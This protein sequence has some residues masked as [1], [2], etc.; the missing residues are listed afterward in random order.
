MTSIR[1]TKGQLANDLLG[2]S[3]PQSGDQL[4]DFHGP[5]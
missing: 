4:Q 2:A 3:T 5:T 1:Q